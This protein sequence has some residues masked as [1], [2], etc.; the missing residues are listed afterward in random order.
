MELP[1]ASFIMI[2][3][4]FII[5]FDLTHHSLVVNCVRYICS[6]KPARHVLPE[7]GDLASFEIKDIPDGARPELRLKIVASDDENI[8]RI[9][10]ATAKKISFKSISLVMM[11]M[12]VLVQK[13]F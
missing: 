1:T 6:S 13:H 7:D 10:A 9:Y 4:Q 11:V 12:R 8:G 5:T 2:E 3:K